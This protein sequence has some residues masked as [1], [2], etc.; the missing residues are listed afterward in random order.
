MTNTLMFK[1]Y[2]LTDETKVVNG[3]TLHRIKALRDFYNVKAGDLGGF[4]QKEENLSHEG[5]AWVG[6]EACVYQD[7]QICDH[8]RVYEHAKVFG[9]AWVFGY[10][11]IY[12]HAKVCGDALIFGTAWF[13]GDLELLYDTAWS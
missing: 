3:I 2:E 9:K 5:N 7:A 8:A 10:A 6:D 12:G 13:S 1:K 11:Q 4:I